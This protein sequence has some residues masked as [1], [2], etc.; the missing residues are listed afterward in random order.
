MARWCVVGLQGALLTRLLRPVYL[1]ALVLGS[2]LH[3]QHLY[4]A[5]GGLLLLLHLISSPLVPA[6]KTDAGARF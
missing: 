6:A 5:I 4:R 1:H 2:L 3:P